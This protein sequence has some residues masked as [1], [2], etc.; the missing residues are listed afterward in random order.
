MSDIPL[1]PDEIA[2]VRGVAALA[3]WLFGLE[4]RPTATVSHVTALHRAPNGDL[5]NILVGEA[6]PKSSLDAFGLQWSRMRAGAILVTGKILRAEPDLRYEL[7]DTPLG[8]ALGQYR[9]DIVGAE[10]PPRLLVLTRG[11]L[12]PNHPALH[13]WSDPVVFTGTE[14]ARRLEGRVK[15]LVVDSDPGPRSALAW[16][17]E[18][19]TLPVSVEAGP[20]VALRLYEDPPAVEELLL[21]IFEGRIDEAAVGASVSFDSS[22]GLFLVHERVVDAASGRWTFQRYARPTRRYGC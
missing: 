7:G 1:H 18:R 12:D 17:R 21:S 19:T 20:S 3:H 16:L 9:L 10:E 22:A 2:D 11:A 13:G 5:H 15:T 4:G 6:A 8:R 14:G